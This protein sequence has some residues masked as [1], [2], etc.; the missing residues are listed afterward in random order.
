MMDD[1]AHQA[2][3][4]IVRIW[5]KSIFLRDDTNG[6]MQLIAAFRKTYNAHTVTVSSRKKENTI[7]KPMI[8]TVI[9]I[10]NENKTNLNHCIEITDIAC[11]LVLPS[12][13]SSDK[14]YMM[15]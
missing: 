5:N 7:V 4:L 3:Q 2:G 13:I 12:F 1:D 15:F 9:I 11:L 6:T 8:P 14:L 10:T